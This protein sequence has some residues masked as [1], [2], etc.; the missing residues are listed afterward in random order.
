MMPFKISSVNVHGGENF[1]I[2]MDDIEVWGID[3]TKLVDIDINTFRRTI[4]IVL[5]VDILNI[6]GTYD[7]DAR[8]LVLPIRGKGPANITL[9]KPV[10]TYVQE[11]GLK[12]LNG[13]IYGYTKNSKLA[14]D[15]ERAEY[16]FQNLF[17][18]N[19]RLGI[20]TN[21][22][23]NENWGVVHSDVSSPVGQAIVSVVDSIIDAI[24]EVIPYKYLFI[25]D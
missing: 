20:E 22:L 1:K 12:E 6:G 15:I 24:Y 17:N 10:M 16:N 2:K 19:E 5:T 4:K 9:H 25:H 21:R 23:L 14:Y 8:I 13:E 11:W 7:I 18:G 3:K